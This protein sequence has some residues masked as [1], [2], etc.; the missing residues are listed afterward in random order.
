MNAPDVPHRY[1][2]LIKAI[3]QE[4]SDRHAGFTENQKYL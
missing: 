4:Y 2:D 3:S 1:S